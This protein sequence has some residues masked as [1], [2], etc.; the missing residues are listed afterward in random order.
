M[1]ARFR[2]EHGFLSNF[3]PAS[4]E[5][6][7]AVYPSVEHAY[8][9][10]KSLDPRVR[11]RIRATSTPGEAKRMGG[12]AD[13][14]ADWER[15]KISIMTGLLRRKF[16]HPALARRLL[17]TGEAA[18]VEGN[19]HGDVFWGTVNGRGRNELG[20]GLMRVREELRAALDAGPDA[21][22]VTVDGQGDLDGGA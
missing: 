19:Q 21:S 18:L 1:I 22:E 14:R 10:A 12:A 16:A 4:V 15:M 11:E 13:L 5:L 6:D 9:A 8:Q 17:G 7:G 2:G 3:H 20:K